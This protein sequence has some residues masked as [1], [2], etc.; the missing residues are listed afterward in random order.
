M[1]MDVQWELAQALW[2]ANQDRPRA[3]QLATEAREHWKRLGNQPRLTR[4]SQWLAI[5][6]SP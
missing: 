3:V 2:S 5:H 1:R 6:A 4:A